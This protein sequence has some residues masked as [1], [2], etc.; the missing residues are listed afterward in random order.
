MSKKVGQLDP[1]VV[2][3]RRLLRRAMI[4][5]VA[6]EGYASLTVQQITDE[7]GLNR[8][9]FYL[10]YREKHDLLVEVFDELMAEV[11]PDPGESESGK[12][13]DPTRIVEVFEH[14]AG[15]ADFYRVMLSEEGVPFFSSRVRSYVQEVVGRWFHWLQPDAARVEVPL[16]ISIPFTAAAYLGA[17]VW[18][19]EHDMPLKPQA[20]AEQLILLTAQGV[21]RSLGLDPVRPA[22]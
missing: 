2:R 22:E 8:A 21:P 6:R 1:R 16:E 15:H 17:I 20:I 13:F 11:T 5:L 19:L 10:H 18:W 14:V 7:A 3:T 9:T 4:N 12:A